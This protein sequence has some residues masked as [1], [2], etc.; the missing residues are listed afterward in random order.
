[1]FKALKQA[2]TLASEVDRDKLMCLIDVGF[3]LQVQMN[4]WAVYFTDSLQTKQII[5]ERVIRFTRVKNDKIKM[6]FRHRLKI[7]GPWLV[8]ATAGTIFRDENV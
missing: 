2:C 7:C 5:E 4:K 8:P 3:H 6:T 1:M